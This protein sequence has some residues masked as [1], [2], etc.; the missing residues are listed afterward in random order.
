MSERPSLLAAARTA[1]AQL[2]AR[3]AA[4]L[5]RRPLVILSAPRA[6]SN[7]LFENLAAVRGFWNIGGESH[8]LF[9]AFPELRAETAALDSGG[10]GRS[11][12]KPGVVSDMHRMFLFLMQD[13][14]GVPWIRLPATPRE[15]VLLEKTPRNALNVPFLLAVF[16]DA[17]FVF[18]HRGPQGNVASIV[19]AW[20]AGLASGQF[21]TFRDLPGWDRPAWCFLLPPG[22]RELVGKSLPEIAAFQWIASNEAILDQLQALPA[23]RWTCVSYHELVEAPQATLR[24]LTHFAGLTV[25]DAG[26][27]QG[28]LPPSRTTLTPPDPHKWRRYERELA[29]LGPRLDATAARIRRLCTSPQPTRF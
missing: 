5:L 10:L 17:R 2:S 6:G 11:H 21:V 19:D 1:T 9:G 12:A 18:L 28:R 23:E 29:A 16:P 4:A 3:D 14:R 25:A 15:F 24:R 8:A 13:H 20:R 26:L 7:L 22:W 27:P